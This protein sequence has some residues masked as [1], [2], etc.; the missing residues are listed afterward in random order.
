ML[1][2]L[3]E[4]PKALNKTVEFKLEES[5]NEFNFFKKIFFCD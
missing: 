5:R 1:V 3:T 2:Y 4:A